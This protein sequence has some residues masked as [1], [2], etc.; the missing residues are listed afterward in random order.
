MRFTSSFTTIALGFV[1]Q[2]LALVRGAE[3]KAWSFGEVGIAQNHNCG[4]STFNVEKSSE[5]P[6]KADC[7]GLSQGFS[8][9][10]NFTSFFVRS[11][12]DDQTPETDDSHYYALGTHGTCT[13]GVKPDD[14]A[15]DPVV[16]SFPASGDIIRDA[17]DHHSTGDTVRVSGNMECTGTPDIIQTLD[18]GKQARPQ[19]VMWQIFKLGD[20]SIP[21]RS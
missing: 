6:L 11:K 7:E 14:S 17:I 3:P 18:P 4:G 5:S 10:T 21:L 20:N 9:V 8:Q 13:F 16:I 1:V 19:K 2:D 12:R 15:E